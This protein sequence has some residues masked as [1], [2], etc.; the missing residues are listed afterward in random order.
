MIKKFVFALVFVLMGCASRNPDFA[1]YKT[2]KNSYVLVRSI[3]K[4]RQR[5]EYVLNPS[6]LVV[7]KGNI[8]EIC[9]DEETPT[10][11]RNVTCV[12]MGPRE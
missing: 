3:T 4:D 7:Q 8:V 11:I 12:T 5:F 10:I 1:M 9:G 2:T 6:Y